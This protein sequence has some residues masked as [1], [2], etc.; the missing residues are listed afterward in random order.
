MNA[1]APATSRAIAALFESADGSEVKFVDG[2]IIGGPPSLK[3]AVDE[4]GNEGQPKWTVPLMPTS[5]PHQ[6]AD[7]P[8][9]GS[10]LA[11]TLNVRHVGDSVGAASGLKMCFASMS[12]GYIAVAIQSFTTAHRLGVLEDLKF[13]MAQVVPGQVARTQNG[14]VN[15]A[16]KAYR[17]VREMQEISR[18]FR[19]EGGFA[20]DMDLFGGAA[21]IYRAVAEDT[22]LGEEKIGK[23]KRGKTADDIAAAVAEGLERKKKKTE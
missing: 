15:M 9:F 12:K 19:E 7:I 17:W 20:Q 14:L 3:P 16:P 8:D 6:I 10:Q 5:G 22:V 13:A 21:A 4:A 23:R 1:V 2:A 18:C 11:E